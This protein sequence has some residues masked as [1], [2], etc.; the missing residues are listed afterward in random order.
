MD[1]LATGDVWSFL[2]TS[3]DISF[4]PAAGTEIM[5]S[6]TN[7]SAD[8]ALSIYLY[9]GVLT[10]RRIISG[11]DT[12]GTYETIDQINSKFF[13]NNTNYIRFMDTVGTW[14]IAAT[15]IQIK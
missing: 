13:I 10:S 15:G 7:T 8:P 9:N 12:G 2:Q 5:V 6:A 1:I 14:A 11:N 4:Q 3:A